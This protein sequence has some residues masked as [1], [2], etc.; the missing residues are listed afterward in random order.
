M[1]KTVNSGVLSEADARFYNTGRI[2][3]NPT[4]FVVA[5]TMVVVSGMLIGLLFGWIAWG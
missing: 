3:R 4:P 1:A 2:G 5:Y